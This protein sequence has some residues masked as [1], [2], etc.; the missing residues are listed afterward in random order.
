M[1]QTPV[2][3]SLAAAPNLLH[4]QSQLRFMRQGDRSGRVGCR[5]RSERTCQP[6]CRR[7]SHCCCSRCCTPSMALS[8]RANTPARFHTVRV[9]ATSAISFSSASLQ[10]SRITLTTAQAGCRMAENLQDFQDSPTRLRSQLLR[11]RSHWL[12]RSRLP[13]S[14]LPCRSIAPAPRCN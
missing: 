6:G 3:L 7:H 5:L 4:H 8:A 11:Q 9:Q 10:R 12:N 14:E 2:Y 13:N 1:L